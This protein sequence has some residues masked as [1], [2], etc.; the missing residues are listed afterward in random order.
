MGCRQRH[1][2]YLCFGGFPFF[3]LQDLYLKEPAS[4][5]TRDH[6]SLANSWH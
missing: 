5:R 6:E 3:L 4:L 2:L 1:G